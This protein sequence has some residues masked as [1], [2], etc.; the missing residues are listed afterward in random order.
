MTSRLITT[1]STPSSDG[2]H[3]PARPPEKT[4]CAVAAPEGGE[5]GHI[6]ARVHRRDDR[7]GLGAEAVEHATARSGF[8]GAG[9]ALQSHRLL[10]DCARARH[11][12][13]QHADR[14]RAF[15]MQ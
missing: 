1:S 15:E 13:Q 7:R 8:A 11:A 2:H 14:A 5:E 3:A 12:D 6:A 10:S 9:H 4:F